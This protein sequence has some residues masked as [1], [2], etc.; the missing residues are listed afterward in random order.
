MGVSVT[1]DKESDARKFAENYRLPYAVGHDGNGSITGAYGLDAT[2]VTL[3]IDKNGKVM[4]R[5]DGEMSETEFEQQI[6]K[7]LTSS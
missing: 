2:P 7:L 5:R 1:W 3:F 4:S 6:D